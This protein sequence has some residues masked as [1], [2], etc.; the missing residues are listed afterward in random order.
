MSAE[1]IF[2]YNTVAR[3]CAFEKLLDPQTH[4]QPSPTV[5]KIFLD[6]KNF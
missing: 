4:P 2:R 1:E 3:L 5:A 6:G